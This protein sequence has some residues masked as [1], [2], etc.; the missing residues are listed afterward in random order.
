M[1]VFFINIAPVFGELAKGEAA[2]I[3]I[4]R[5]QILHVSSGDFRRDTCTARPWIGSYDIS[6]EDET[7][8]TLRTSR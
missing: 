1:P 3:Q 5:M 4:G 7:V 6:V 8:Q 2:T